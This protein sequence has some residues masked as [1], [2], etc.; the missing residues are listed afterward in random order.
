AVSSS[1]FAIVLAM[2][3]T[4]LPE[5]PTVREA[6]T[7]SRGGETNSA[8]PDLHRASA[9]RRKALPCW[10]HGGTPSVELPV[11][12]WRARSPPDSPQPGRVAGRGWRSRPR[13]RRRLCRRGCRLQP[14]LAAVRAERRILDSGGHSRCLPGRPD[15]VAEFS[16]LSDIV[17]TDSS[18]L[19]SWAPG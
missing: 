2:P 12:D 17:P 13:S 5:W 10:G 8:Q 6:V 3:Q 18:R 4:S 16:T 7:R 11:L 9:S 19:L 15:N 14:K 1:R